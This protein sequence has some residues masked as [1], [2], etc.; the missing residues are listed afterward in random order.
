MK[1][2]IQYYF[3][4]FL[5]LATL[6]QAQTIAFWPFDEQQGIYPSCVLSDL[7]DNDY[8][9]VIGP[10]G[11]IVEGKFGNALA[12]A[13]QPEVE[14]SENPSDV[15]FG[16]ARLEIPE[17]RTVEP[18]NW[19]NARFTALMTRGE[20]HL[21][22]EA[23][24]PHVTS[25]KLNLGDFDWTIEFWFKPGMDSD[26][27]GTVFEIGTGPR[28]E[29]R[30]IT[31]LTLSKNKK[32][33]ILVNHPSDTYLNIKTELKE[34]KWQHLAFVYNAGE[35]QLKHFVDGVLQSLPMRAKLHSLPSGDEDYMSIG[36]NGLW[37]NPLPGAIDE[38]R[39]SEGALFRDNFDVPGSYSYLH[40]QVRE[41]K[42]LQG[43]ELLFDDNKNGVPDLGS[44]KH[45][46]ID[47]ALLESYGED[48]KFVVNPPRPD[49]MVIGNIKGTFRKHLNVLED[50]EGRIRIYT[51]VEDDYLAVWISD[52]GINFEAPVLP[53]G[54]YGKHDNIVLHASVGMG[55]VFLD[56]N[57]PR[58]ERYKYISDYHRRAVSLFYSEDGLDFKRYKQPVLPFRS[59][60]QCNIYYDDQ[61]QVYTAFHRSDFG[62]TA[63]GDTE[64]DFVMTETSDIL[65][66]WPFKPLS[67]SETIARAKD[68][69]VADL[70]PWYLDNGPL[71]PGGF[72]MEYPWVFSPIDSFDPPETDIYVPKAMKYPW[73]PDTYL[74]FP[75]VYFHYEESLP[76][77]RSI[78]AEEK[79]GRGSGPLESQLAVS[80]N[81]TDWQRYPRPAYVGI[82]EHSGIDFKTAYIAHG[83]IKQGSEI[84]QYY[85][86]EPH[87]HS[88]WKKIPENR[89]VLRLVQRLDGF[90]SLDS[91]YDKEAVAVTRPFIFDG[92]RLV[93]N[94][95][96]DAAGY[97]QVGFLDENKNAVPGFGVDDC[98]YING[99]FINTEVEWMQNRRE[100][101]KISTDDDEDN[102]TRSEKVITTSDVSTLAGKTVRLIF[103]MRGAKLYSMKFENK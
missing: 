32:Y 70:I 94:I 48:L 95:D 101:V 22:N 20:S 16:L 33:F 3:V 6:I 18:M 92:N 64:R 46:F 73:A 90:V 37:N 85:F 11:M 21:R 53:N 38:L 84:W 86:G 19:F 65:N 81:G 63:T 87:Y 88:P 13:D 12:V 41:Q 58:Q 80:R 4:H 24:F 47:D 91:P 17:G 7:S 9:L 93:L 68:K 56:P 44:G 98:I 61:K 71:T 100:I 51:T 42:L 35:S 67:V 82:G 14:I 1:K 102:S 49:R 74:A 76:V 52:D 23:G 29:N 50:H 99:D 57:A 96:T 31:S 39:F 66:P 62:R 60:S 54:K 79:R 45:L 55:M 40:N 25:T 97:A 15:K 69:R 77:T 10:G 89:S 43:P 75:V 36:R 103:R 27:E 26:N 72:S 59:G 78:L 30:I 5:L 83:M 34:N 2:I 8:P 28:G